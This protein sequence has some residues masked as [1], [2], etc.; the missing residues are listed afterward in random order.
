[1]VIARFMFE[2]FGTLPE[3]V[4]EMDDYN[5]GIIWAFLEQISEEHEKRLKEIK[6][7]GRRRTVRP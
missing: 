4:L 5:K 3:D 7:N 2:K 6:S 1:M